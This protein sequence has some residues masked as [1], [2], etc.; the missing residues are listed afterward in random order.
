MADWE[1]E[2]F[3]GCIAEWLQTSPPVEWRRPVNEWV[4]GLSGNIRHGA[5]REPVIDHEQWSGWYCEIPG[6]GDAQAVVVAYYLVHTQLPKARCLQ[7]DTEP[8]FR[9]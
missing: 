3:G 6:A 7:I 1:L 8:R 2:D 4:Q 9:E 5:H